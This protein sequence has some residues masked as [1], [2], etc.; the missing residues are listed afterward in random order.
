[1]ITQFFVFLS[2]FVSG[3]TLGIVFD[4]FRVMRG[5]KRFTKIFQSILDILFGVFSFVLISTVLLVSNWGEV[6][7]Y[8]FIFI[9][10][11]ITI[12]YKWVSNSIIEGYCIFF[13]LSERI[14]STVTETLFKVFYIAI[15]PFKI[16]L[17]PFFSGINKLIGLLKK[18]WKNSNKWLK[19]LIFRFNKKD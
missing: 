10:I 8:V 12:H 4:F 13:I 5:R 19:K 16:V 17:M 18:L 1:M 15:F 14:V 9:L 3:M 11:G 6:R 7:G 2:L